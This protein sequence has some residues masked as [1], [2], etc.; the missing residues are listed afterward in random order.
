MGSCK[1]YKSKCGQCCPPQYCPPP[2]PL[3]CPP[4]CPLPCPP[5][6]CGP[7]YPSC[8]KGATGPTGPAGVGITTNSDG[9]MAVGTQVVATSAT[10]SVALGPLTGVS[11][12]GASSIAIGYLTSTGG[13][14]PDNS[15]V[16]NATGAPLGGVA[17]GLVVAPINSIAAVTVE[18]ALYY[19][20][21]TFEVSW[22]V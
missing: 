13:A 12:L 5:S 6:P 4:P 3:P 17:S 21:T 1:K 20:T 14:Q 2:C 16:I 11:G 22:L 8:P 19:N 9:A 18:K 15:I 10:G 7:C